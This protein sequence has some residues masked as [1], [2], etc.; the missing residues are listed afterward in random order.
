MGGGGDTNLDL[1]FGFLSTGWRLV[2]CGKGE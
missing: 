2:F 1:I